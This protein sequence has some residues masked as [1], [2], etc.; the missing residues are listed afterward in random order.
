[1]RQE[2]KT[3]ALRRMTGRPRGGGPGRGW[4]G[5]V[6]AARPAGWG[7][8]P[9][10]G[11]N[12]AGSGWPGIILRYGLL[13]NQEGGE[14]LRAGMPEPRRRR[15]QGT[16]RTGVKVPSGRPPARPWMG[17]RWVVRMARVAPFT[18]SREPGN[19]QPTCQPKSG[20]R[21]D[22]TVTRRAIRHE[23]LPG[24]WAGSPSI[25]QVPGGRLHPCSPDTAS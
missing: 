2:R 9:E 18:N 15:P 6:W 7:I 23:C 3:A 4:P 5:W 8:K 25:G 22:I 14:A 10:P 11:R 17:S 24:S 1:M 20:S 21:W 12:P 19:R 16:C 13:P